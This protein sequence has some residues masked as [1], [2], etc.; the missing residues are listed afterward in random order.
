[1]SK[2]TI[3]ALWDKHSEHIGE[4]IDSFQRVAGRSLIAYKEFKLAIEEYSPDTSEGGNNFH[5]GYACACANMMRDYGESTM[6]EECLRANFLTVEEMRK[7]GVEEVDI[8]ILR[9]VINEIQRKRK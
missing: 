9:P 4:D 8:E 7:A 3:E 5:R 1:M 2:P 6:V